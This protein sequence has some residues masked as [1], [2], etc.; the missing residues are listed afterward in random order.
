MESAGSRGID[1][2]LTMTFG[3]YKQLKVTLA[4]SLLGADTQVSS[5]F[6][7]DHPSSAIRGHW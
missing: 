1:H 3:V 5:V 6:K 2:G 7:E 4:C